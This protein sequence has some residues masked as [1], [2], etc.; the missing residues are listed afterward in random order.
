MTNLSQLACFWVSLLIKWRILVIGCL[1]LKLSDTSWANIRSSPSSHPAPTEQRH[2]N[3]DCI[4]LS[5]KLFY[6]MF[7]PVL[8]ILYVCFGRGRRWS[9]DK[10][11]LNKI[12][13]QGEAV[14]LAAPWP[15]SNSVFYY[16]F[17]WE[18]P[19]GRNDTLHIDFNLFYF[20]KKKNIYK[21]IVFFFS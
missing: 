15:S 21:M 8:I 6:S 3:T 19:S 17:D 13:S 10:N 5:I 4:L 12:S 14:C 2:R 16:C 20:N 18:P 7:S 1:D 9:E 11:I